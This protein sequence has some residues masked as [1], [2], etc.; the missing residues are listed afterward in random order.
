MTTPTQ[1]GNGAGTAVADVHTNEALRGAFNEM[2]GGAAELAEA[3][4]MAERARARMA[5]AAQAAAD[6]V[7]STAFDH[8]AAAAAHAAADAAGAV[9]DGTIAQWSERADNVGSHAKSG[10]QSL[11]KYRES[12]DLVASERIDARVLAPTAS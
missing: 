1:T 4:A 8:G 7:S 10:L 12:E 2:Q 5:A 6:A 11:E 3:A 9:S